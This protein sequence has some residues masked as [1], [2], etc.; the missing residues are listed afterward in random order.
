MPPSTTLHHVP[1]QASRSHSPSHVRRGTGFRSAG[2]AVEW[3][4][5]PPDEAFFAMSK[6]LHNLLQGAH[7]E[8]TSSW[9]RRCARPPTPVPRAASAFR[10]V[11]TGR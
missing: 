3:F 8:L 5:M 4:V 11:G 10:P 7:G 9:I 2:V 6:R 1:D